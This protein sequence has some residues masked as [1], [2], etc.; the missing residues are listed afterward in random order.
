MELGDDALA[1]APVIAADVVQ[2]ETPELGGIGVMLGPESFRKI[3]QTSGVEPFGEHVPGC[4]ADQH[5]VRN[6]I[7]DPL[8]LRKARG[9]AALH[10]ACVPEH[11]VTETELFPHV[12]A[13]L[14][15]ERA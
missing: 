6:V 4:V 13:E 7:D 5:L 11:K 10:T 15:E 12:V 1:D 14:K 9:P 3:E 8:Q 2:Q